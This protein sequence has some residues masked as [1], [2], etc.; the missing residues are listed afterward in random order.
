MSQWGDYAY[1]KA[2]IYIIIITMY[3]KAMVDESL[4]PVMH[5]TCTEA[6]KHMKTPVPPKPPVPDHLFPDNYIWLA[7]SYLNHKWPGTGGGTGVFVSMI[8]TM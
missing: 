3:T 1:E 5:V 4:I 7:H 2:S 6:A 8:I